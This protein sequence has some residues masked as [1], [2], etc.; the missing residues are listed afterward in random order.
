ML[1]SF[2]S[3]LDWMPNSICDTNRPGGF[4]RPAHSSEENFVNCAFSRDPTLLSCFGDA[5]L[6]AW[7]FW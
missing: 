2:P 5:S 1:L 6:V 3:W 7:I 4:E